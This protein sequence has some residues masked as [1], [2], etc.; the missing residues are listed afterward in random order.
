MVGSA[1]GLAEFSTG[2]F[3]RRTLFGNER[4]R[5]VLAAFEPGQE[6]PVHAPEVDLVLA[7]LEGVGE[8]RAGDQVHPVKAG[9][10]A[11]I[12]AGSA[13]GVRARTRLIALHVVSPPPGEADH[14]RV[15]EGAAWP[16]LEGGPDVSAL[17]L[18]E[19]EHL[20]PRLEELGALAAGLEA[21]PE[22]D[23]RTR[24]EGALDFLERG[25]LPHAEEEERSIYPAVEGLLR[26][27]GGTTAT[28]TADH[29]RIRALV[30]EL[31]ELAARRQTMETRARERA[32]LFGLQALLELHFAKENE[33]YV[34]LLGLLSL[35][36]REELHRRLAGEPASH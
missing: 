26:A 29:V 8:I 16:D 31:S 36:E 30:Q 6:I 3:G 27:L 25:L 5:A 9:D 35:Q 34:P 13:R 2:G 14:G 10:V 28:M 24:L 4:V 19:H 18:E 22:P 1:A 17:V 23:L 15:E 33:H 7:V 32:L 20:F 21:L 12:P 11:V